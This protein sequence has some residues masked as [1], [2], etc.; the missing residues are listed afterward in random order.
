MVRAAALSLALAALPGCGVVSGA[1]ALV[2]FG[3]APEQPAW[4]SVVLAA[5]P[6]ANGDSA[7]A[8]DIV[9]VKDKAMVETLS[10]MSAAK[11]FDAREN[12]VRTFPDALAVLAVEITPGQTLRV[13]PA[14]Y[15]KER[16]WAALAFAHYATPGEHRLRLALDRPRCVLQLGAREFVAG[17]QRPAPR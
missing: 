15:R 17:D 2:G 8:V 1:K 11:Y 12:L 7:L 16:A 9:L 14:R 10:A 5:A 13:A 4:E 6:D 3:P